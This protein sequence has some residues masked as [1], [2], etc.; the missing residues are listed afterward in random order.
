M[1]LVSQELVQ[2]A[3]CRV[4][5]EH[6]PEWEEAALVRFRNRLLDE[7]GSAARPLAEL[8][9]EAIRRGLPQRLPASSVERAEWDTLASSFA[10]QWSAERF[11]ATDMARWAIDAWGTAFRLIDEVAHVAT[12]TPTVPPVGSSPRRQAAVPPVPLTPAPAPPRA[13]TGTRPAVARVPVAVPVARATASMSRTTVS[14]RTTAGARGAGVFVAPRR[15]RT[16]A[17]PLSPAWRRAT[18]L[19]MAAGLVLYLAG[20]SRI[21]W[22][23]QSRRRPTT[24][25]AASASASTSASANTASVAGA[26]L[27]VAPTRVGSSRVGVPS[28]T[29]NALPRTVVDSGQLVLVEPVRRATG[30]ARPLAPSARAIA[31]RPDLR[32]DEVYLMD[33]S[34]MQG[35]VDIVRAGAIVF[36]DMRT[37]LRHELRKEA[38]DHIV[39]EF[40]NTVQFRPSAT[41]TSV[42]ASASV[43]AARAPR[44]GATQSLRARGVS[45]RYLI[46][47]GD[48]VATG[49]ATCKEIWSKTP[50]TSDW[51]TVRHVPGADT[52]TIAFEA[53]DRF[54]TVIDQEGAFAS[55][56][57]IMP[58]Q[59]RTSTA[60]T[61]R[62]SGRFG[63]DGTMALTV[64]ILL[65]RR[66]RAA[67]ADV[68]CA[69]EVKGT[70]LL[71]TP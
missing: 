47:Y 21:V 28:L 63:A 20:M 6:P 65:F 8:L 15:S 36:L 44:S 62:L 49:S 38:I 42:S 11:V 40:G 25:T 7:T 68:S 69:I 70:G 53:G 1:S 50:Q 58:D 51:A 17:P 57:R 10:M 4:V 24:A 41:G 45:G 13:F 27:P 5:A 37:G 67:A 54:A 56:P 19:A 14:G 60:L 59:A 43:S 48:A 71:S 30:S 22:S 2:R 9:L 3:L 34:R 61:T 52:L 32:F 46:R 31:S 23:I 35:R 66:L 12:P 18:R 39:T 16:P 29:L 33:G 55:A 26:P 64:N